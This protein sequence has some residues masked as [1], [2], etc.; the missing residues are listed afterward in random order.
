MAVRK[1]KPTTPGQRHKIIGTFEEITASVP[2]KSLVVG[3]R[4]TG[5]RNNDGINIQAAQG[6]TV[7]SADAGTVVY[8]GNELK[9]FGNLILVRHS[10]GWITAY[11]HNQKLLVKKGQKVKRGEKIATVGATGGVNKPQLHFE[12]RAGK[13]AVNPLQYL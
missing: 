2:E 7:R 10:G 13:K 5:G 11:A 3:K 4:S 8:A 12:V 6:S 1:F 9:G